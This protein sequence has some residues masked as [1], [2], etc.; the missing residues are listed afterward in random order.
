M[1]RIREELP[2]D[3]P[4]REALLDAAFGPARHRKT[5]NRLR[6]ARLPAEGL[7]LVAET[8]DDRL[9]ATV[10]LW[11][12]AAASGH[13]MLLLGPLAVD[14]S[15]RTAGIGAALMRHAIAKARAAGH[16]AIML[17]GDPAYYSRF[18]FAHAPV[19]RLRLPGPVAAER[20]L[21]LELVPGALE[22]AAGMVQPTGARIPRARIGTETGTETGTGTG[23]RTPPGTAPA[24]PAREKDAA[25]VASAAHAA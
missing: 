18:G 24:L 8:P 9:I 17:V 6:R 7:A 22:G 19:A 10:R 4:G 15:C 2:G 14:A 16:G 21:G 5:C 25:R 3:V 1:I 11:H 23:T 12:V 13:A 20:L